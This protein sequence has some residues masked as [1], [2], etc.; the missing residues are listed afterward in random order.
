VPYRE[1]FGKDAM[2]TIIE[3]SMLRPPAGRTPKPGESWPLAREITVPGLGKLTMTGS[4]KFVGMSDFEGHQCAEIAVD[5]SM[6]NEPPPQAVLDLQDNDQFDTLSWQMRLKLEES[7]VKGT[8]HFD[9]AISFPRNTTITQSLS[10]KAKIPDGTADKIDMPFKQ[11][12][13][14]KLVNASDVHPK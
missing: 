3:Q 9:P 12:I 11:T 2:K 8:I 6:T 13:T 5:A 1:L 14:V 4:Y 7:S 10:V